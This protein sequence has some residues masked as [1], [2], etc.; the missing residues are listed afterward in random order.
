MRLHCG[1][2]RFQPPGNGQARRGPR[3]VPDFRGPRH[4]P[5]QP[6]NR[7]QSRSQALEDLLRQAVLQALGTF[8]PGQVLAQKNKEIRKDILG[9]SERYA[10]S[11]KILGEYVDG[12]LY[13]IQGAVD[14]AMGALRSDA[15]KLG[16]TPAGAVSPGEAPSEPKPQE[17]S[18]KEEPQPESSPKA[19]PPLGSLIP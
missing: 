15:E 11:F 17:S 5:L 18:S 19:Q 2:D 12:D 10:K 8:V 7:P 6:A 9:Q 3:G 13:R 4:A 1:L 14:V 16:L